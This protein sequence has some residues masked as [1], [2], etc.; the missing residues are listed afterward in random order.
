MKT[1][2]IVIAVL[3]GLFLIGSAYPVSIWLLLALVVWRLS[4]GK[5]DPWS[6]A[7]SSLS[8]M[9][10]AGLGIVFVLLLWQNLS[11][12]P[13]PDRLRW[14]ESS[15]IRF[16]GFADNYLKPTAWQYAAILSVLL[17]ASRYLPGWRLRGN[18]MRASNATGKLIAVVAIATNFT[19]FVDSTF[20]KR[21]DGA[22]QARYRNHD[23][24]KNKAVGR[25]L[26]LEA[27]TRSLRN[28]DTAQLRHVLAMGTEVSEASAAG[29]DMDKAAAH[30]AA[31]S[32]AMGFDSS[33]FPVAH[34]PAAGTMDP[35][36]SVA[37][38]LKQLRQVEAAAVNAERE[39]DKAAEGLKDIAGSLLSKDKGLLDGVIKYLSAFVD[40]FAPGMGELVSGTIGD[41]ITER[42][43]DALAGRL[44]TTWQTGG[45][46]SDSAVH[47]AFHK[48]IA[49]AAA[50]EGEAAAAE[51]NKAFTQ[52]TDA[53]KAQN[54]DKGKE[55]MAQANAAAERARI[56]VLLSS[57]SVEAGNKVAGGAA[58]IAGMA[59]VAD[60]TRAAEAAGAAIK[61]AEIAKAAA[62]AA[63]VAEAARAA[64]AAKSA[65][66]VLKVL[67]HL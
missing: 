46:M 15:L 55:W 52:A 10:A 33:L 40:Q 59:G 48:Q 32:D 20:I 43:V 38:H 14:I 6:A 3:L 65:G 5:K 35:A 47:L 50:A 9:A 60:A 24:L 4:Q 18:F 16:S 19:F 67:S 34:G 63:E 28:A 44:K 12:Y 8:S 57:E 22:V 54:P 53:Y 25:K 49:A 41:A 42:A 58:G 2:L 62:A 39:A 23:E 7:L 51:A 37:T 64:E 45:N 56:D 31:K 36:A 66:T 13:D 1:F 11:N 27:V 21:I 30:F 17:L 29:R 26:A 61:A